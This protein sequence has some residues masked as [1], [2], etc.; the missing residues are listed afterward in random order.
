[1][2]Y[3]KVIFLD[4]DGVIATI[5][6][7]NMTHFAKSYLHQYDVY[8]FNHK[9]VE[10]L[11]QILA[12]TKA[13]IIIS[14]DWRSIFSPEELNDIFMINGVKESPAAA[15]PD[16][17][18]QLTGKSLEEIR[19]LEIKSFLKDNKVYNYL[20]VDDLDMSEGFGDNFVRC[21]SSRDGIKETGLIN[22]IIRSLY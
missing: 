15:T 20:V 8:P 13:E 16:L 17:N 19:I 10:V 4:I 3:K 18:T 14:S 5:Y 9:C 6:E 12:L 11:N 2:E 7:F 21:A 22:K 1:M